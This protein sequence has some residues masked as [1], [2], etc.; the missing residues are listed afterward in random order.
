MTWRVIT[1]ILQNEPY[2]YMPWILGYIYILR[3]IL[4]VWLFDRTLNWLGVN[5]SMDDFKG[6]KSAKKDKAPV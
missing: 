6:S 2:V 5:N 4:P 3:G 1:G